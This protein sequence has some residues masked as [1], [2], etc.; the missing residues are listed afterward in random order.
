MPDRFKSPPALI[1][2]LV[3]MSTHPPAPVSTLVELLD[4][5]DPLAAPVSE[6]SSSS[7]EVESSDA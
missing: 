3:E 5:T 6:R 7:L 1:D 2:N 4:D